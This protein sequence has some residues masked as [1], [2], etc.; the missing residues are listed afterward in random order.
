MNETRVKFIVS[1][2]I[3]EL[4]NINTVE[5]LV[6]WNLNIRNNSLEKYII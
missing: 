3:F 5:L 1:F 6:E 4:L 2:E